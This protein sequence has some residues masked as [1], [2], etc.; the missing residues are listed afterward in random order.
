MN[1]IPDT[2][3]FAQYRLY[4]NWWIRTRTKEIFTSHHGEARISRRTYYIV[5][6]RV[7]CI[8]FN[9]VRNGSLKSM[10]N[11]RSFPK[12]R[13]IIYQRDTPIVVLNLYRQ[14]ISM[15]N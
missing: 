7:I 4:I 5:K 15:E 11:K 3:L 13:V 1:L 6:N 9:T 8:F 14:L 12:V 2:V 10:H